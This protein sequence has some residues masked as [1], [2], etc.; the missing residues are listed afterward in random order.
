MK[1]IWYNIHIELTSNRYSQLG[2]MFS[3]TNYYTIIAIAK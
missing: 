3:F 1:N 2:E